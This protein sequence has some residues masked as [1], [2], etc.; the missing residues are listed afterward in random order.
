MQILSIG[1]DDCQFESETELDGSE[2]K[3]IIVEDEAKRK[4]MRKFS[5]LIINFLLKLRALKLTVHEI[6]RNPVFPKRPYQMPLTKQLFVGIRMDN[7][8]EVKSILEKS[9]YYVYQID[10][11][12][13]TPMH[14]ACMRNNAEIVD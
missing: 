3:S 7:Y 9:K 1:T 5:T 11:I 10:A 2:T 6:I 14:R 12:G 4:R 13:K 8:A